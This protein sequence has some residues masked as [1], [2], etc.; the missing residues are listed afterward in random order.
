M[1]SKTKYT[2]TCMACVYAVTC[3]LTV[4]RASVSLY[5]YLASAEPATQEPVLN[6]LSRLTHRGDSEHQ[7]RS[8][9]YVYAWYSLD[10]TLAVPRSAERAII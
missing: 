3:M 7:G 8:R 6:A 5:G 4:T 9:A 10:L 2:G 1:L